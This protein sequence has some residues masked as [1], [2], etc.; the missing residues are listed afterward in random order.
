MNTISG[1]NTDEKDLDL[2]FGNYNGDLVF[3]LPLHVNLQ[4]EEL[5]KE[6]REDESLKPYF[7]KARLHDGS[8]DHTKPAF[9]V[10]DNIVHRQIRPITLENKESLVID[11]IVVP[12]RLRNETSKAYRL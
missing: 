5:I 3:S 12:T 2:D 11:Q 9:C 8:L 1:V 4:R 6:Q 10:K 7:E